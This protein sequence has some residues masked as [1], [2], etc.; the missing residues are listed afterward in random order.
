MIKLYRYLV[1]LFIL[2]FI[3]SQAFASGG[4]S[5]G[6][7]TGRGTCDGTNSVVVN[8]PYVTSSTNILMTSQIPGGAGTG[9]VQV[10]SRVSGTSFSFACGTGDTSTVAYVLIEP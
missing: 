9:T 1:L 2:G 3:A 8:T 4:Y 7:I 5:F 10:V 6:V